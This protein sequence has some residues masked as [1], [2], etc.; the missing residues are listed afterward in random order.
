MHYNTE[1]ESC[2][3]LQANTTDMLKELNACDLLKSW[4]PLFL[5]EYQVSDGKQVGELSENAVKVLTDTWEGGTLRAR[6]SDV[7][8]PPRMP[9]LFAANATT[10][11]DWLQ[12]IGSQ[13]PECRAAI[14]KR[15]IFFMVSSSVVP[16]ELQRAGL[17]SVVD[18]SLARALDAGFEYL[19]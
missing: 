8:L 16:A 18:P 19:G 1:A 13:R 4:V 17:S 12:H 14:E 3:Y 7:V 9:R 5:D 11:D 2:Y 15:C 6:Y 10:V